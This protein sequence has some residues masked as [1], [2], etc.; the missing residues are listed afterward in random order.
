VSGNDFLAW[1]RQLG[2]R[3]PALL[4]A[5]GSGNRDVDAADLDVWR[6]ALSTPAQAAAVI[7]ADDSADIAAIDL[8]G[9]IYVAEAS[10]TR[11]MPHAA[12]RP[13]GEYRPQARVVTLP[14]VDA[15]LAMT[16]WPTA[17]ADVAGE[18]DEVSTAADLVAA[19]DEVFAS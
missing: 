1:Q 10:A 6:G 18:L 9:W 16:E 13:R 12:A 4:N 14:L 17:S 5:D 3:T 19:L 8:G 15:A 2:A 7:A 11:R